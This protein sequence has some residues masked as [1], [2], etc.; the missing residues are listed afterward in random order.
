[1]FSGS[2]QVKQLT[3]HEFVRF[4]HVSD[5]ILSRQ[6]LSC[7]L[8]ETTTALVASTFLLLNS[9]DSREL[10]PCTRLYFWCEFPPKGP[11]KTV[12]AKAKKGL[13]HDGIVNF[14]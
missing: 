4:F 10:A 13:K 9:S 7:P 5:K 3:F 6:V 2:L 8:Q 12:P 1:L 11:R 14:V